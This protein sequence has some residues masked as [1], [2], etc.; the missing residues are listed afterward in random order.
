MRDIQTYTDEMMAALEDCFQSFGHDPDEV[1]P[2]RDKVQAFA[3][4][5]VKESIDLPAGFE[6]YSMLE[7]DGIQMEWMEFNGVV[8]EVNL[9][10]F[11]G[12]LHIHADKDDE[13]F[14]CRM[15]NLDE[16]GVLKYVSN[17]L[18]VAESE[19]ALTLAYKNFASSR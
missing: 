6:I 7:G 1:M 4:L 19:G 12:V 10:N 18:A 17:V 2:E 9:T 16:F 5:L 8:L 3:E 14:D 13:R 11:R 15:L